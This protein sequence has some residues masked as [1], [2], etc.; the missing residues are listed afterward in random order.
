MSTV[1][2]GARDVP[3]KILAS[4][5]PEYCIK[6]WT[7]ATRQELAPPLKGHKGNIFAMAFSPDGKLLATAGAELTDRLCHVSSGRLLHEFKGHSTW[8]RAV[9]FSPDGRT[10]ATGGTDETVIL[11]NVASG[12]ELLTL[13]RPGL[14]VGSLMFSSSGETLAAGELREYGATGPVELWQAPSFA[15]I[16]EL[17]RTRLEANSKLLRKD[18]K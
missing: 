13:T 3:V 8:V 7:L 10:L 4:T 17:E 14:I 15:E 5:G 9:A 11:W 2:T 12:Q 6:L 1:K 18:F 16:E